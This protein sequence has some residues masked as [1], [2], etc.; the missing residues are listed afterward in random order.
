M[1][2]A[3]RSALAQGYRQVDCASFYG[4]ETTIGEGLQDFIK[5]EGR[6]QLFV[7]SK[8]W[9]DA[10]RP[11][12]VR[13]CVLCHAVSLCCHCV[14][15]YNSSL[16]DLTKSVHDLNKKQS[17]VNSLP[18]VALE[19]ACQSVNVTHCFWPCHRQSCEKTIKDLNCQYL[20]LYLM[21]WPDAWEPDSGMPGKPDKTVT[22]Q[23]TW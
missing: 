10:H 3:C 9:N 23:Q 22:I 8:V 21:H 2:L 16:C 5:E 13:C 20:D 11:H 1:L 4:N 19:R 12:L 6:E 14:Q 18:C 17:Y 15:M 7:T